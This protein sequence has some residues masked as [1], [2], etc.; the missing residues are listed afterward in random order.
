MSTT[1]KRVHSIHLRRMIKHKKK[2]VF[3]EC[4]YMPDELFLFSGVRLGL[5]RS[6]IFF[7]HWS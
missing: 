7:L 6:V 2:F 4:F 3:L 1:E 5:G